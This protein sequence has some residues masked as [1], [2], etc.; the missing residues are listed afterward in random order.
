MI[1][2]FVERPPPDLDLDPRDIIP[3]YDVDKTYFL[4]VGPPTAE[5]G[6]GHLLDAVPHLA[7]ELEDFTVLLAGPGYD[8]QIMSLI[9]ERGLTRFLLPLGW[10]SPTRLASVM[11]ICTALIVTSLAEGHPMSLA[12]GMFQSLPAVG[13][14]TMGVRDA[15]QHRKT[16]ILVP[17]A[18]TRSL[19]SELAEL[20]R[21]DEKR[22]ALGLA[23]LEEARSRYDPRRL[24]AE[25]IAVYQEVMDAHA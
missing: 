21:N 19:A 9:E 6:F 14:E 3:E 25:T 12:E 8:S 10:L 1:P 13:F 5:K 4:F 7:R 18:D 23:S 11:R 2:P 16:G 22:S 24:I 17:M 15:I 20:V